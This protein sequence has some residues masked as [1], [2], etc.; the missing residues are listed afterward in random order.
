MNTFCALFYLE[1]AFIGLVSTK[2][3]FEHL[4]HSRVFQRICHR[5]IYSKSEIL[6]DLVQNSQN[7]I[8]LLVLDWATANVMCDLFADRDSG[9]SRWGK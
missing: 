6:W 9:D 5:K 3:V 7:E 1:Y 4:E 2:F 8:I